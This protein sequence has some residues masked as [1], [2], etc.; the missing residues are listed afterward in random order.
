MAAPTTI[1]KI[2]PVVQVCRSL[3]LEFNLWEIY[4]EMLELLQHK[5]QAYH[6][7]AL[8]PT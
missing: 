4:E 5:A 7:N 1:T 8:R 3:I 6:N 2:I